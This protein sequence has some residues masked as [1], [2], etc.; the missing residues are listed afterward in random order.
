MKLQNSKIKN[1]VLI[2]SY[3]SF[4]KITKSQNKGE[5]SNFGYR[6]LVIFANR[7]TGKIRHFGSRLY[8]NN[9]SSNINNNIKRS[10]D[11]DIINSFQNEAITFDSLESGFEAIKFSMLGAAPQRG[12]RVYI[13]LKTQKTLNVFI[14]VLL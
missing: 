1:T 12:G 11:A 3:K 9:P 8:S 7:A 13:Y 4:Y 14:L 5:S 6:D 2:N 10:I